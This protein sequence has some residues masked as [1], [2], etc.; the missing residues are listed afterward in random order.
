MLDNG[1]ANVARRPD[2]RER[3][4]K[5][6]VALFPRDLFDLAQTVV[7]LVLAD[8]PHLRGARFTAHRHAGFRDARGIGGAALLVDDGVHAIDHQRQ[9]SRRQAQRREWRQLAVTARRQ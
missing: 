4:E 6:V 1:D 7:A 3:D 5:G 8:A 9:R 2:R